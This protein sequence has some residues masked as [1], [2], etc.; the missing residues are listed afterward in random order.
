MARVMGGHPAPACDGILLDL[1]VSSMQ[2]GAP[3]P[4]VRLLAH[5]P[6]PDL[7]SKRSVVYKCLLWS[8]QA[9]V[10]GPSV[11]PWAGQRA[12]PG[13]WQGLPQL[14][15]TRTVTLN[16]DALQSLHRLG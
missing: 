7:K 4:P 11:S 14:H 10:S 5:P 15:T 3:P 8:K 16:I 2:V 6:C 9:L 13:F 12:L 1:G